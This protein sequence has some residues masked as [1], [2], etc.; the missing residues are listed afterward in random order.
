MWDEYY[1]CIE[2]TGAYSSSREDRAAQGH[3]SRPD[4]G[5]E[6]SASGIEL[7]S[8]LDDLRNT[9]HG[10]SQDMRRIEKRVI[11]GEERV[12]NLEADNREL[13]RALKD[14]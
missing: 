5:P 7:E 10:L 1:Y 12:A 3:L 11:D 14:K 9:L 6:R 2:F 8:L 13:R 4:R